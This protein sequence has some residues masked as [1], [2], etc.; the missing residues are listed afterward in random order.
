MKEEKS[1]NLGMF[2]DKITEIIGQPIGLD[3]IHQSGLGRDFYIQ[4]PK[5]MAP[6][7][8]HHYRGPYFVDLHPEDY[9]DLV[10]GKVDAEDYIQSANWQVGYYWGGG[11]ML[12]GGY[13][14]P[15]DI[16][17]QQ[18]AVQRYLKILS[19][20]G[21]LRSSGYMPT[22]EV[23]A[24]CTVD[25]CPF[26]K[27]KTGDWTKEIPEHDPR[28][29]LFDALRERFKQEHAGYTLRGFLCGK[30]PEDEIWISPNGRY[31]EKGSFS[32]TA[33]ASS[34]LIRSLLMHEVAPANWDEYVK[35]FQFRLSVF[36]QPIENISQEALKK[37]SEKYD[38][39][40][41]PK[42]VKEDDVM[43]KEVEIKLPPLARVKNFFKK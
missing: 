27:Y 16:V 35:E 24:K 23:C 30:I 10:A 36:G 39:V 32:F 42:P 20:R 13:Y 15:L 1:T 21:A 28:I 43:K 37:A 41:R 6:M 34:D 7:L 2:A 25:N 18:A 12:S 38:Y 31:S 14:Q 8:L 5:R 3:H 22:Q 11:S 19:C 4:A 33:H 26:S 9:E 17:K 29:D 40:K